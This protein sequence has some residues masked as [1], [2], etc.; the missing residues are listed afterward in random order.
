MCLMLINITYFPLWADGN[1]QDL[2]SSRPTRGVLKCFLV[3]I[4]ETTWYND[5]CYIKT[6]SIF[7]TFV[8]YFIRIIEREE[9]F[10]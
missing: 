8:V 7:V 1:S 10:N 4:N 9:H 3:S 6:Y 5:S 2:L